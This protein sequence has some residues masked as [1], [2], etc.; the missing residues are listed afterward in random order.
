[1]LV[2]ATASLCFAG[3][4]RCRPKGIYNTSTEAIEPDHNNF[5]AYVGGD[6]NLVQITENWSLYG[7]VRYIPQQNSKT[8]GLFAGVVIT[9]SKPLIN[10][11]K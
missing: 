1:M 11:N 8:D 3:E 6:K 7:Q 10:L 5:L 4:V 9:D 2:L